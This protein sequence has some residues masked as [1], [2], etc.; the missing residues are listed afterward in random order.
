METTPPASLTTPY[1]QHIK[2]GGRKA[3]QRYFFEVIFYRS[4]K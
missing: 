1:Q 4:N 3:L 2:F